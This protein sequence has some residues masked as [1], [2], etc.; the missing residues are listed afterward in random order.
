M[1]NNFQPHIP[2]FKRGERLSAAR[3]NEIADAV[4][5]MLWQKQQAYGTAFGVTQPLDIVGK[6]DEPLAPAAAFADDPASA[7][8]SVWRRNSDGEMEDS[9]VNE[10]VFNRLENV[11]ELDTGTICY[12]RWVEGE[13][14]VYVADCN[15]AA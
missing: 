14:V 15:P 9:G 1:P 6:L 4:S 7:V 3:L 11:E 8:L 12:C 13:W 2:D 5:R 10:T